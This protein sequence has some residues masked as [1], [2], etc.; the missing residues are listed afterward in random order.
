MAW[1]RCSSFPFVML[2]FL[3]NEA[4]V[5]WGVSLSG[6]CATAEAKDKVNFLQNVSGII[7]VM[8][9]SYMVTL[10]FM[11]LRRVHWLCWNVTGKSCNNAATDSE[12]GSNGKS[13]NTKT[14]G[15]SYTDTWLWGSAR[16]IQD[17]VRNMIWTDE[18]QMMEKVWKILQI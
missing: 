15:W 9:Y 14:K 17:C 13:W 18:D 6:L 4:D 7:D 16:Q 1:V 8:S 12:K 2:W 3:F 5:S 11:R 10:K